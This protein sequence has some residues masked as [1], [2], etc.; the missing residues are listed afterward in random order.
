MNEENTEK[1][2]KAYPNLYNNRSYFSFECGDGWFD[3]IDRLSEKLEGL[4]IQ[5]NNTGHPFLE[6]PIYA[7][8]VKEKYGY[9][10]FYMSTATDQ[11]HE[12]IEDA[13]KES[14]KICEVCGKTGKLNNGPWYQTL[15]E[16]HSK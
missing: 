8:Q 10:S 4:I 1:L 11:M 5:A 16:E 2:V 12:I 9:L 13:S 14:S 15:C 7:S 3:L 6:L